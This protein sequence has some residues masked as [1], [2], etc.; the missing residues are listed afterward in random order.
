[1][2]KT[3]YDLKVG[4]NVVITNLYSETIEKVERLTK[5]YIVVRNLKYRKTDGRLSGG[6]R[7]YCESIRIATPDDIEQIRRKQLHNR[8]VMEIDNTPLQTLTNDQ[9]QSILDIIKQPRT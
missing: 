6:G 3:L 2:S 5:H 9:L 4:D 1:M 7:W 8:L